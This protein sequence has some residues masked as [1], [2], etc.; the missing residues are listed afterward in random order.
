MA[1][2]AM[3]SGSPWKE[4]LRFSLPLLA[5][6]LLQ[7]FY[8]TADTLIVGNFSGEKALSAV[9]TTNTLTFFFLA[10]ALGFST[11]NG[12]LVA[13][14]FGAN[15]LDAV[16]KNALGGITAAA[17]LGLICC[18][19]GIVFSRAAYEKFVAVPPEILPE[20]SA[21]TLSSPLIITVGTP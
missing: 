9:G 8:Q 10:I 21:V 5:G 11:G 19:A 16:R 12:V 20:T 7:Q 15:K 1:V 17:A 18:I 13:Q 4:L 14:N 2:R 6:A 3:T